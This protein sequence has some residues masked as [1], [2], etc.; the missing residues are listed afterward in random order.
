M[1]IELYKVW[2]SAVLVKGCSW[3]VGVV[4]LPF[5]KT[6]IDFCENE[7][8]LYNPVGLNYS[9]KVKEHP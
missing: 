5:N 8:S 6:F 2:T 9:K 4:K 3:G 1:N 7:T